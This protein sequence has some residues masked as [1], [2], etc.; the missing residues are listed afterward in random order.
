MSVTGSW[1]ND[2]K[3]AVRFVFVGKWTWEEFSS[4]INTINPIAEKADYVV[5]G[6]FDFTNSA[7]IPDQALSNFRVLFKSRPANSGVLVA[8]TTLSLIESLATVFGKIYAKLGEQFFVV[9]S[10]EAAHALLEERRRLRT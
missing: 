6:I 9:N 2:D 4:A 1:D 3:Q 7:I 5:D 10:I 8:V